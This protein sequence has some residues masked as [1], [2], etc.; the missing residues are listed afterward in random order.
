MAF[1]NANV[2]QNYAYNSGSEAD[3]AANSLVAQPGDLL[4]VASSANGNLASL[5]G[6]GDAISGIAISDKTFDADNE[7][8]DQAKVL[9]TPKREGLRF[10]MPITGGTVTVADEGKLY[11][12]NASQ[13][14]DGT[15]EGTGTQLRM[16]KFLSATRC[17]FEI[18]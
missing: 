9:Y 18:A 14:V 17:E 12:I 15:T 5:T 7:T 3:L 16:T 6:A 2:K 1:G 8:V 13:V 11:N 10:E 4:T